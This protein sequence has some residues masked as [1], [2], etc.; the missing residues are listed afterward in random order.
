MLA[1][2]FGAE[3]LDQLV[4]DGLARAEHGILLAGQ[5]QLM[6]RWMEITDLGHAAFSDA[7]IGPCASTAH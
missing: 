7:L 2:G 5:R 3:L 1:H 4:I 6:V